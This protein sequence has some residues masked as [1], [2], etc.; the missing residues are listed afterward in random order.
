VEKL[1]FDPYMEPMT[2]TGTR[3]VFQ[4]RL[5]NQDHTYLDSGNLGWNNTD[6][7]QIVLAYS[8][9]ATALYLDGQV[10]VTGGGVQSYP[11]AAVRSTYGFSIGSNRTGTEQAKAQFEELETFNYA[12]AADEVST[13]YSA[14][15]APA[16]F[17]VVFPSSRLN[18]AVVSGMVQGVPSVSLATL[19]N[20]TNFAAAS[21]GIFSTNITVNLGSG[22]GPRDVWVGL[23]GFSGAEVWRR[24]RLVLDTVAPA[25]VITEP[26]GATTSRPI[27]Q[28]KGYTTEPLLSLTYDLANSTTNVINEPGFV[29]S[30]WYD[31][32]ACALTTNWFQLFDLEL[33]A[34][35]NTVTLRAVD[36]AGNTSTT[37]L[38]YTLDLAGDTTAPVITLHWP[39]N[40]AQLAADTFDLRGQLDD[41]TATLS[42]SGLTETPIE[43]VVERN[44][45]F[46]VEGLPLAVGQNNLT[47]TASDAAANSATVNLTL[48]RGGTTITIN[49]MPEEDLSAQ[50]VDVSGTVSTN[51]HAVWVNGVRASPGGQDETG[52]WLWSASA[53]PLNDGGTAILQGRAI[54]LSS[55]NG[56]GTAT[57]PFNGATLGNPTAPGQVTAESQREKPAKCYVEHYY[58]RWTI[59]RTSDHPIQGD[60][61]EDEDS[62][63]EWLYAAG[64]GG[65]RERNGYRQPGQSEPHYEWWRDTWPPD[66]D[67]LPTLAGWYQ[68]GNNLGYYE[69]WANDPPEIPLE[70][71]GYGHVQPFTDHGT[72]T[73]DRSAYALYKLQTGGKAVLKRSNLFSFQCDAQR[74]L[75][76]RWHPPE[77]EFN[78]P[79]MEGIP[80]SHIRLLGQTL[81]SDGYLYRVLPDNGEFDI[82]P[83]ANAEFYVFGVVPQKHRL[84]IL[85]NTT[86]LAQDRV[87]PLSKF[88]VGQKLTFSPAFSPGI[89]GLKRQSAQWGFTGQYVNTSMV[90]GAGCKQL[91]VDEKL[92]RQETTSAWWVTGQFGYEHKGALVDMDLSFDNGQSARVTGR[93]LFGMHRPTIATIPPPWYSDPRHASLH[94]DLW[95]ELRLDSQPLQV[96]LRVTSRHSGYAKY[97][98]LINADTSSDAPPYWRK[99]HGEYWLDNTDP[100]GD[101]YTISPNEAAHVPFE[102]GPSFP[103]GSWISINESFKAYCQFRPND[104]DPNQNIWITLGRVDWSWTAS[105]ARGEDGGWSEYDFC[106]PPTFSLESAFPQWF[107][108]IVNGVPAP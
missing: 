100:Y 107:C 11:S 52:A 30:Q 56:N 22:D 61:Y 68:H 23:R 58:E 34:G 63:M 43:G 40:N 62:T 57:E 103:G 16:D 106:P 89:P 33:A 74:I 91:W 13:D 24:T 73:Y 39:Q 76:P 101:L 98:Q 19:V 20:S 26:V 2:P 96:E 44:G 7:H 29:M 6:W 35:A 45:L 82:T 64:G 97:V 41:P 38:V 9:G 47:L 70:V 59:H 42:V 87:A 27:L 50:T 54:P 4:S 5:N 21:W 8:P 80:A 25:V 69:A 1:W 84:W 31:T 83:Q 37:A 48:V 85:A 18:Y 72:D 66:K 105:A 108:V 28:V 67:W 90:N 94:Y 53:V 14:M 36:L 15:F 71:C 46:W 79:N 49:E 12:L 104:G 65:W 17:T 88:C 78:M 10:P 102:D 86:V 92:L 99:T 3:M 51:T 81:G 95:T 93:G 55:N 60:E 32:N 77:S 75:T